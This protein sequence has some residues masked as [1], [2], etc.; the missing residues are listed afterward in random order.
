[1]CY[2]AFGIF[3]FIITLITVKFMCEEVC[4]EEDTYKFKGKRNMEE[5]IKYVH[6]NDTFH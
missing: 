6:R 1:M 2:F 4:S 5:D 3:K